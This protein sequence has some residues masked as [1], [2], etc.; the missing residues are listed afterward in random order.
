MT[1]L[2]RAPNSFARSVFAV[3]GGTPP[4][5]AMEAT[6]DEHFSGKPHRTLMVTTGLESR[7]RD[8]R[9]TIADFGQ[10]LQCG[11][12][13]AWRGSPHRDVM[14]TIISGPWWKT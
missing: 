12:W 9:K 3:L 8:T 4:V 10:M 6:L 1:G 7:D 11:G 14:Q 13:S 2:S 5:A